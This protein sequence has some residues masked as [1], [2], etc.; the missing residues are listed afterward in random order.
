MAE[1]AISAMTSTPTGG[2]S[3]RFIGTRK[4][5]DGAERLARRYLA[6]HPSTS[7]PCDMVATK[8]GFALH[9]TWDVAIIINHIA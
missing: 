4:T 3:E 5:L 1:Y 6:K 7:A 9:P 2:V 8:T